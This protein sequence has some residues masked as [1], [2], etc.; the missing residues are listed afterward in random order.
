MNSYKNLTSFSKI[1]AATSC[2]LVEYAAI[3]PLVSIPISLAMGP[4]YQTTSGRRLGNQ[5]LERSKTTIYLRTLRRSEPHLNQTPR[6]VSDPR[7]IVGPAWLYSVEG[8][9]R[10]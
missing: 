3:C 2:R 4:F 1:F 9:D 5:T 10:K 8:G 6:K 7:K